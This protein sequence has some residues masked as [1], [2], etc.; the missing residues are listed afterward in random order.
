MAMIH[1]PECGAR[2]SDKATICPHCGYS[3]E[4]ALIPIC[5]QDSYEIAPTLRYEIKAWNPEETELVP[6]RFEDNKALVSFLANWDRL[7]VALPSIANAIKEMAEKEHIL[8]A[9]MDPYIRKLIDQGV[10]ELQ[11]DKHG[12]KMAILKFAG[13]KEWV[14]QLRLE[15]IELSPNVTQSLNHLTDI[16]MMTQILQEIEYVSRSIRRIHVELQDDRV[17]LAESAWDRLIQARRMEDARLRESAIMGALQ[18]AT[19]AKRTLMRGFSRSQ[20]FIEENSGKNYVQMLAEIGAKEDLETMA[21]DAIQDLIG[22][23]NAVRV[24]CEGY[25]MLGEY[26]A[27]EE[28]LGVFRSFIKTNKLD[29]RDTLLLINGALKQKQLKVVNEFGKIAYQ[30]EELQSRKKLESGTASLPKL[31]DSTR[32]EETNNGNA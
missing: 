27:A 19:E 21:A 9:K 17:A 30:I 5:K 2:I 1:C 12:E 22:I 26:Q 31:L 14:Q 32:E 25:N 23:T 10:L 20:K 16:A 15:D 8:A 24:E 11:L 4:D 29:N 6:L 28:C 13:K 18:T 7:K 3:G